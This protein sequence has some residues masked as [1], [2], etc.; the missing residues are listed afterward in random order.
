MVLS[1]FAHFVVVVVGRSCEMS[2]FYNMD[3]SA[4][5]WYSMEMKM[6]FS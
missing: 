3:V 2:T 1:V 6:K 5:N 4:H